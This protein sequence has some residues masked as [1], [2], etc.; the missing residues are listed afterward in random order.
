MER[1]QL[2]GNTVSNEAKNLANEA[3]NMT[4]EARDKFQEG[5]KAVRE[6]VSHASDEITAS[7]DDIR[8]RSVQAVD[9]S[10]DYIRQNPWGVVLGAAA[11][12]LVA[13]LLLRGGRK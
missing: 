1:T 9:A 8:T 7:F 5:A 2:N 12:G 6:T 4:K 10:A 3:K 13:G 11:V